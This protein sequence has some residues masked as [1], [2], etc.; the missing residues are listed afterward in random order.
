MGSDE[1]TSCSFSVEVP[2]KS[3]CDHGMLPNKMQEEEDIG[4]KAVN[5]DFQCHQVGMGNNVDS[6]GNRVNAGNFDSDG[7]NVN[8]DP[9]DNSNPN[10]ALGGLWQF[11]QSVQTTLSINRERVVLFLY[12]LHPPTKHSSDFI[13]D[14]LQL[15]TFFDIQY[16]RIFSEAQEKVQHVEL[17]TDPFKMRQLF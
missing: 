12:R 14:F 10:I 1:G 5:L 8:N 17:S 9:D 3:L 15:Q 11:L 13:D 4:R 2:V 6:N 7:F 16:F